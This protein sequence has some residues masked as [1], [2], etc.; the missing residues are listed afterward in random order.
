MNASAADNVDTF[1]AVALT[2]SD[3]PTQTE[4]Q[5][6]VTKLNDLIATLKRV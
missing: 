6:V 3:P 4:V 5:A 2:V 1:A